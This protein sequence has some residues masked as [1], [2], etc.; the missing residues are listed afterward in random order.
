MVLL[1]SDTFKIPLF[2]T[3]NNV[4]QTVWSERIKNR[5]ITMETVEAKNRVR[6]PRLVFCIDIHKTE[7]LKIRR[8]SLGL[9]F[10]CTLHFL[11]FFSVKLTLCD[12]RMVT[13]PLHVLPRDYK[14]VYFV[15]IDNLRGFRSSF[16][17]KSFMVF[18]GHYL[19]FRIRNLKLYF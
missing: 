11:F 12:A 4:V 13:N 17:T 15:F 9:G 19:D 8:L 3:D 16:S 10:Q 6:R 14:K 18:S 2:T 1:S 5:C 7:R